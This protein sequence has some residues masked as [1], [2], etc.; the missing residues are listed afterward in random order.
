V[1]HARSARREPQL[2]QPS[3]TDASPPAR[4]R[5]AHPMQTGCG[6]SSV[7]ATIWLCSTTRV[8]RHY[9]RQGD[10]NSCAHL[11]LR[12]QPQCQRA[13][14]FDPRSADSATTTAIG[15]RTRETTSPSAAGRAAPPSGMAFTSLP[16]TRHRWRGGP[17]ADVEGYVNAAESAVHEAA[18][19]TARGVD[20]LRTRVGLRALAH[21]HTD[22]KP[23]DPPIP[24]G[25]AALTGTA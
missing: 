19:P 15:R 1:R 4:V 17:A 8:D 16:P 23:A 10:Q 13:A 3:E 14:G 25:R 2:R 20:Q 22:E 24:R 7:G 6:R 5:P 11:P 18:Y 21:G 9:L 12:A